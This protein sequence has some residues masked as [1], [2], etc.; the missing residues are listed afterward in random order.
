MRKSRFTEEQIVKVLKEH[1]A[2]FSAA[3]V[4]REHGIS[5]ATFYK[6]RSQSGGMEISNAQAEGA[7][8]R[9]PQAQ[10]AAGRDD[11][12]LFPAVRWGQSGHRSV[13]GV[14]HRN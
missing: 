10:E 2:G 13:L 12:V 1:A 5:D 14:A 7:R 6:W 9:E 4:C 8:G 11:G 3:D